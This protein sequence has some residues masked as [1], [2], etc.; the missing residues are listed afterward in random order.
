MTPDKT[1][2]PE[3]ADLPAKENSLM[4]TKGRK[5]PECGKLGSH[6]E[7]I[8]LERDDGTY[9]CWT[10][11]HCED[12]DKYWRASSRPTLKLWSTTVKNPKRHGYEVVGSE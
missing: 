10:V 6:D 2:Q 5:C 9:S 12:C 1:Y 7:K 3:H 11:W 8:A 4:G